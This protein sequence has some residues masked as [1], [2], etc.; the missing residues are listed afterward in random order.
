MQTFSSHPKHVAMTV[1]A[2]YRHFHLFAVDLHTLATTGTA[3]H[4]TRSCVCA[5]T[6]TLHLERSRRNLILT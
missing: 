6:V 4:V 2:E 3:G 5:L 1:T